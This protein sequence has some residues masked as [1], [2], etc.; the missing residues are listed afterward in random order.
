M[1]G[2]DTEE[3]GRGGLAEANLYTFVRANP[4]S[5]RLLSRAQNCLELYLKC[6]SVLSGLDKEGMTCPHSG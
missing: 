2:D 1:S 6:V 3:R 4:W 5:G